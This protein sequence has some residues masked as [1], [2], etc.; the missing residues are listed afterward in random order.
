MP[1]RRFRF[2]CA[3]IQHMHPAVLINSLRFL[4]RKTI[5]LGYRKRGDSSRVVIDG[6]PVREIGHRFS[7]SVFPC[8]VQSRQAMIS[9]EPAS[10]QSHSPPQILAPGITQIPV[11]L[12][13]IW[14]RLHLVFRVCRVIP[15][16]IF[17][18]VPPHPCDMD[19]SIAII[20][21]VDVWVAPYSC[22]ILSQ[23]G[24]LVPSRAGGGVPV[25]VIVAEA[26]FAVAE[27]V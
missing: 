11:V 10:S 5:A 4:V 13:A 7:P 25:E 24:V 23:V 2:P 18:P 22:E 6:I 14:A 8:P 9:I 15:T 27:G 19:L 12:H 21:A 3:A 17:H 26:S 20:Q 1:P 16:F